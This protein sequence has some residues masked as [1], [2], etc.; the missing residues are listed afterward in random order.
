MVP[1]VRCHEELAAM[2][3]IVIAVGALRILFATG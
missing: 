2:F 3:R 1:G